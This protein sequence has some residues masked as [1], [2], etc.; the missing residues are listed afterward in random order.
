MHRH[1][2]IE[3]ITPSVDGGRYAAKGIEGEPCRV[4]ADIFRDGHGAL[5]AV[6]RWR[7]KGEE[8]FSETTLAHVGN[9]RFQGEF[10]LG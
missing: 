9:D 4:E 2:L 10:P 7:K 5:R 1:I 8:T 3:A 6:V